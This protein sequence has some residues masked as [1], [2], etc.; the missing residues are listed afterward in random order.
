MK[1]QPFKLQPQYREY[2]W[3]GKRIRP[4]AERTAEAWLVYADNLIADGPLKGQT[5]AEASLSKKETLL[6][7]GAVAKTG[8]KFPV[9]IKLLDS[10]DWLSLQVHPNDAQAIELE[11]EG[12]FGKTE[13]W[14]IIDVDEGA[15]LISGFKPGTTHEQIKNTIGTRE[16]LDIVQR[17]DMRAGDCVPIMPGTLHAGGPGLFLYEIQQ[18]SDIT[19]RVYDWDRPKKAGRDLHIEKALRVLDP[20]RGGKDSISH[21]SNARTEMLVE[22]EYFRLDKYQHLQHPKPLDTG[23]RSFHSLTV[24][25]GDATIRGDGWGRALGLYETL[26]VPADCGEFELL[27]GNFICLDAYIPEV[28][29]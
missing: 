16:M 23:N 24:V 20:S 28:K 19:Y 5:L 11:G 17:V 13:A 2:I 18:T 4:D 6:G 3:G 12:F 14:Y 1:I 25:Q 26:L 7:Y 8:L 9:L 10:A 29:S 27:P 21:S 15:Q 22:C